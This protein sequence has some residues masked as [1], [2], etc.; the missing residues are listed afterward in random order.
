MLAFV[1]AGDYLHFIAF[2]Y[3]HRIRTSLKRCSVPLNNFRS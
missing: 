2:F 1:F 3:M